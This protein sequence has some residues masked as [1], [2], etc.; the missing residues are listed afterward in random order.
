[1]E[2]LIIADYRISAPALAMLATK[3]SIFL[4]H[5]PTF[6][7]PLHGH[8][9]LFLFTNGENRVVAPDAPPLL[10]SIME[11]H[12]IQHIK[13]LW[14]AG[15]KHPETARYNAAALPD[16]LIHNPMLTEQTILTLYTTGQIYAVKQGYSRCSTLLLDSEHLITSDKGI[17]RV[18]QSAGKEALWVQSRKIILPGYDYGLFGGCCG[19][20]KKEI[21]L[22]GT[23]DTVEEVDEIRQ[24]AA[25]CG[26][27][28]VEPR[29]GPLQDVG[30]IFIFSSTIEKV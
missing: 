19:I 1:M 8:P 2:T 7:G 10:L 17:A 11:K 3:G 13:G 29:E 4:F 16:I 14:P 15:T 21:L 6:N 12:G 22:S 27:S 23:L 18:W 26:F 30:G 20:H 28:F 9:D 24:F 5:H 25:N